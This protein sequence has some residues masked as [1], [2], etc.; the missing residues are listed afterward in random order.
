M[1][2]LFLNLKHFNFWVVST[3]GMQA[4]PVVYY[5]KPSLLCC[6][7]IIKALYLGISCEGLVDVLSV[8]AYYLLN[9][10]HFDTPCDISLLRRLTR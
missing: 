3:A 6:D 1:M 8:S 9:I 5:L 7:N 4:V 2:S 10:S